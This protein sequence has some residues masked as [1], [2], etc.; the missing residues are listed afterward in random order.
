LEPS[1]YKHGWHHSVPQAKKRTDWNQVTI[2]MDGI[3]Q[4]HKLK[5]ELKIENKIILLPLKRSVTVNNI[6]IPMPGI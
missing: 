6:Y 5:R 3:I 2:N 4:C 1:N